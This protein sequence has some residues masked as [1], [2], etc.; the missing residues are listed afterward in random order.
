MVRLHPR[1]LDLLYDM[2]FYHVARCG[3]MVIDAHLITALVERWRPET[4]TFH[5]PIGETTVTLQDVAIIWGLHIDGQ[6]LPIDEHNY[7]DDEWSWYCIEYL[8]FAPLDTDWKGKIRIKMSAISSHLLDIEISD[9]TEQET[10]D[11]YARGCVLFMLG[12]YM[13]PDSSRS[14]VS[15]LY[16]Q[17]IENI[18][19]AGTYSWGNAVLA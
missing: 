7:M 19:V 1:V 3:V 11:Q 10:V 18:A 15:L 9:D 4:H 8:G 14:H 13:I 16:L 6:P 5:F 17:A 2:G 12:S